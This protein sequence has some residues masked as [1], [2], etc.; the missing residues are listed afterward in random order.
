MPR[1]VGVQKIWWNFGFS[2]KELLQ[3]HEDS[4]QMESSLRK[5]YKQQPRVNTFQIKVELAS[6]DVFKFQRYGRENQF[7]N[8]CNAKKVVKQGSYNF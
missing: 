7:S 1:K 2:N 5:D 8:D 4:K 3:I 6:D